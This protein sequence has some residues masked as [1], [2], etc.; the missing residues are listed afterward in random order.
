[1]KVNEPLTAATQR[2]IDA[3][4]REDQDTYLFVEPSAPV[5]SLGYRSD[6]GPLHDP[7]AGSPRIVLAPHLYEPTESDDLPTYQRYLTTWFENRA[8]DRA[9]QGNPPV[10]LGEFGNWRA[11][12]IDALMAEADRAQM[13]WANW[14]WSGH[15][16]LVDPKGV[17]T[18]VDDRTG[19]PTALPRAL[20]RVYPQAIAGVP[21][22]WSFDPV[23]DTFRMSS[24]P[25][26]D[27]EGP[28]VLFVPARDRYPTGWALVVD[29]RSTT[30]GG[31][32]DRRTQR[33]SLPLDPTQPHT[34]CIAPTRR[35]C[36]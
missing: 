34:V 19:A 29:G 5:V 24:E 31:D 33:L 22:A 30:P 25:K 23:S 35:A 28:T 8:D 32:F 15:W 4:R 27:A 17:V 1:M 9:A 7:R 6:L 26:P 2:L 12:H 16:A 18:T 11:A 20:T 21:T 3:A 14:S 13:S 36:R 10:Y